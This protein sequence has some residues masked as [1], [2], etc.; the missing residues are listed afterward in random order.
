MSTAPSR[1]V[2]DVTIT[3][4]LNDCD[5]VIG[6]IYIFTE[7]GE[8]DLAC[9]AWDAVCLVALKLGVCR[10]PDPDGELGVVAHLFCEEEV[11]VAVAVKVQERVGAWNRE[12]RE[13]MVVNTIK[14]ICNIV[15]WSVCVRTLTDCSQSCCRQGRRC[16]R[17]WCRGC[18]S[19]CPRCSR[20]GG[21]G[22]GGRPS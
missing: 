9:T 17:Q 4:V 19:A 1:S 14:I 11:W 22:R 10:V 13:P 21:P 5:E 15:V 18:L 16:R 6:C 12:L 8:R 7:V 3:M 2:E 20:T